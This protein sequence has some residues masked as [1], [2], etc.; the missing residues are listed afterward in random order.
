MSDPEVYKIKDIARILKISIP[1][2]YE[3]ARKPDFPAIKIGKAIRIS[4]E[5]F[6]KWLS[7]NGTHFQNVEKQFDKITQPVKETQNSKIENRRQNKKTITVVG[8]VV[9]PDGSEKRFDELTQ[10][11]RRDLAFYMNKVNAERQGFRAIRGRVAPD[12]ET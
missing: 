3:L 7:S 6:E 12:S 11:E 4:K 2:A 10:Q 1:T 9:Y 5:A 8:I